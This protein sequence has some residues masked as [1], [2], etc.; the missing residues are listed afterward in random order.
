MS[1]ICSSYL[2]SSLVR[3]NVLWGRTRTAGR[4]FGLRFALPSLILT[5]VMDRNSRSFCLPYGK[6]YLMLTTKE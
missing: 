1:R 3:P 4:V 6:A 2:F 5:T